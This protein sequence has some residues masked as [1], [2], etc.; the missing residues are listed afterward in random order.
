MSVVAP[1][2]PP[3]MVFAAGKGT[4]MRPLTTMTPKPLIEVMGRSLID[5]VID[6]LE[7]ALPARYV[8]NV[9]YLADL[10]DV[11]V[12][13]RL[14]PRVTVSDERPGLLD[15]GGGL[16]RALPLLGDG[17]VLIANADTF[18]IE[19]ASSS[20]AR[21]TQAFDPER[22][23]ALLLV[24]PTVKAVGYD[25]SG[26]FELLADGHLRRRRERTIAPFVYAGCGIVSPG[27]VADP[28]GPVFSLNH[29]FDRAIAAGRLHGLR[30]DG[31][32][33]HVGTPQAIPLAERALRESAA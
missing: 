3:A 12:R 15:T 9:S 22:M 14:G 20:M 31:L 23:D 4:R 32:W 6:R 7:T 29:G 1:V 24:A 17:P 28:P 10:L 18:W 11:H 30:L 33:F 13:R 25:G 27:L 16:V 19:G 21:L 26:D 5:H 8:V 2:G